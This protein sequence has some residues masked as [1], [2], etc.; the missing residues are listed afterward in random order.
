ME[1]KLI[2]SFKG[3]EPRVDVVWFCTTGELKPD[4]FSGK[5]QDLIDR[6]Y[7]HSALVYFSLDTCGFV[8]TNCTGKAAQ[9]DN[10]EIFFSEGTVIR[11]IFEI[12]VT[13]EQ[14]AALLHKVVELDGTPYSPTVQLLWLAVAYKMGFK[15]SPF[16]DGNNS[17]WC[18]EFVDELAKAMEFP[19]SFEFV[20]AN[21]RCRITPRDNVELWEKLCIDTPD[22]IREVTALLK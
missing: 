6:D 4:F 21:H 15:W 14:R 11:R 5:I 8:V 1:A 18:S 7:S 13:R 2:N 19:A 22:R 3:L 9:L 20:E 12:Q 10:E 16:E 17:M